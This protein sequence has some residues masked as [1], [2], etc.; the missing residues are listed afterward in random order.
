MS[1]FERNSL[2][3]NLIVDLGLAS[4]QDVAQSLD[5]FQAK[6]TNSD[7]EF[8]EEILCEKQIISL[9]QK[10]R[11]TEIAMALDRF[12]HLDNVQASMSTDELTRTV[13]SDNHERSRNSKQDAQ[14]KFTDS[15]ISPHVD[16]IEQRPVQP[17]SHT[18]PAKRFRTLRPF[19]QGGLGSISV[20]LDTEVHRIVA[21][22]EIQPQFMKSKESH[23][24]FL[25]EGQVT[26]RLEH[27]GI[28]PVYSLGAD[29]NGQPYY[30][31]RLIQGESMS[32][33]IKDFY[34][35]EFVD[36]KSSYLP[37]LRKT[38]G[39]L[40]DV[41]MA[42]EFAHSQG[43]LHRDLKPAN[44]MLGNYGETL[45]VDWGLAKSIKDEQDGTKQESS[46]EKSNET[47]GH[48][49]RTG[50]TIGTVGYMSPEQASG[51]H[52]DIT[53]KSDVFCLG[54][55]LYAILTGQSPYQNAKQL[56][57]V[58]R[59]AFAS[60]RSL[61]R[62]V[63]R[64]LEAICV[65][66]MAI[67]PSERYAS[68]RD[69]ADDL[70]N[71]NADQPIQAWREPWLDHLGRLLRKY[72]T[73]AIASFIGLLALS[74]GLFA[75]NSAINDKN[76]IIEQ[77]NNDL[78]QSLA[79][80]RESSMELLE[81]SESKLEMNASQRAKILENIYGLY[82]KIHK[83]QD[84][85][86]IGREFARVARTSANALRFVGRYEIANTRYD[87]SIEVLEQIASRNSVDDSPSD[88]IALFEVY[89]DKVGILKLEDRLEKATNL[90]QRCS[91]LTDSLQAQAPSSTTYQRAEAKV[92][93]ELAGICYQQANWQCMHDAASIAAKIFQKLADGE[94]TNPSDRVF[95]ALSMS[96]HG[97]S[98]HHLQKNEEARACFVKATE[99]CDNL[100]AK[101]PDRNMK[102]AVSVLY[103]NYAEHLLEQAS[104]DSIELNRT[105]NKAI[106]ISSQNLA[107]HPDTEFYQFINA[108]IF[109]VRGEFLHKQGE[110]ESARQVLNAA[111]DRSKNLVAN[112]RFSSY[113]IGVAKMHRSLAIL[114]A[115]GSDERV[116]NVEKALAILKPVVETSQEIEIA[117]RLNKQLLELHRQQGLSNFK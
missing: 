92:N 17:E 9:R 93:Y 48:H 116:K 51:N 2:M 89:I 46:K 87:E 65:K 14:P 34:K 102:F 113:R 109:R 41:C 91:E 82:G 79:V 21:L 63:P 55:T 70:A 59:C 85:E 94:T 54:S 101:S 76:R 50:A 62:R 42:I 39:R 104:V 4:E 36:Q 105:L 53:Q 26:G 84:D 77:S 64:G 30:A 32:K 49:T 111:L 73:I 37:W 112:S 13:A 99:L 40:Q 44:I 98:L 90:L 110:N 6:L 22:K 69:L 18:F 103:R 47:L 97:K 7:H 38:I 61:N 31:M 71:W 68:A 72:R 5:Q 115:K 100:L 19:A 52:D 24:R 60:P 57:D 78:T 28:V 8:L 67:V 23:H 117:V 10:D 45:V 80:A 16:P 83:L 108:D 114:A 15:G 20:A 33:Q 106:R 56:S 81:D 75:Y 43:I 3:A 88:H 95:F 12:D 27:P 107:M 66:A 74:G 96:A 25:F 86:Q 11:L 1:S 58:K 29:K 35:F